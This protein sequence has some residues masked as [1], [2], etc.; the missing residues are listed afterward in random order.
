MK[1]YDVTIQ[2]KPLWQYFCMV[3][4]I[5]RDLT[6]GNSIFFRCTG[7]PFKTIYVLLLKSLVHYKKTV[8]DQRLLY[9]SEDVFYDTYLAMN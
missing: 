9:R 8:M 6:K 4:F 2:M 3:L 5:S 7:V 1:S